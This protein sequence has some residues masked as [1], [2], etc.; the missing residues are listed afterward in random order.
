[1][2][3]RVTDYVRQDSSKYELI[4][5]CGREFTK[6]MWKTIRKKTKN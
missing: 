3:D 2:D 5:T 6:H 4:I 1:M